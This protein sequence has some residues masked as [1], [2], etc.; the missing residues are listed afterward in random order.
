MRV[1]ISYLRRK[2]ERLNKELGR[3]AT[4]WTKVEK[5]L[6]GNIGHIEIDHYQPGGNKH[7]YKLTEVMTAGGG[8]NEFTNYRMTATE[9]DAY[10]E[11]IFTGMDLA[12][13][14]AH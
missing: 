12:S 7:T 4:A 3:P 13:R 2:V 14:A 6:V 9:L 8:V 1:T 11:G 5:G 10:I